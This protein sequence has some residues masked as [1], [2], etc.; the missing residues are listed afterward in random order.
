MAKKTQVKVAT[1]FNLGDHVRIKDLAGQVG[2]ISELRGPLGPGGASVYRVKVKKKPRISYI[3]LLGNQLE[4]LPM[5]GQVTH[6]K[7]PKI[8]RK[9]PKVPDEN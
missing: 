6:V 2:R 8:A 1:S 5:A 3:E 4:F 9:T 7:R